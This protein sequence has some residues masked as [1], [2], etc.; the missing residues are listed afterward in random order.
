MEYRV[1]TNELF[2]TL[3]AWDRLLAMRGQIRLIACGGT[4]LTLLGYKPSTKDI[5]FLVPVEKEHERLAA[6]LKKAGYR[7]T[8][9]YGWRRGGENL[10]FDLFPG[11]R[12]YVTELLTS[13]LEKGGHKKIKEWKKIYLGVLNSI[14]LIITKLFRGTSV[15]FED[16]MI[17][18]KGEKIDLEKLK[19]RYCET[20]SYDTSEERILKNLNRFLKELPRHG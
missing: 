18:A 10:I 19:E 14:D 3:E 1:T 7:E 20:A 15:D 17:L 6:F 16:C 2:Q 13:P 4:A 12:V 5:D 11:N 9:T 8:S